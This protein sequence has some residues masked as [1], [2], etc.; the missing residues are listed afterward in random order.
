MS[1]RMVVLALLLTA[2]SAAVPAKGAEDLR[3]N[4]HLDYSS[5]S[6]DGPL[7]TGDHIKDGLVRGKP[8]YVFIYGEACFNSKR[9]ARRTV[10]LYR[11]Y[12]RRVRFVIIDLDIPRSAQQQ[13]L[14][15]A[16]YRGFIPHVVVLDG[17]ENVVYNQAGEVSES[18]ISRLLDILLKEPEK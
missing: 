16:Y 13:E 18:D 17:K 7:I 9:Q 15:K 12:S 14:V 6:K 5:D 1:K 4:P 3:L 11:K 2:L 10:S 8:N